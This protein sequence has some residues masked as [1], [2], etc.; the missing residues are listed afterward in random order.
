VA[1][2]SPRRRRLRRA[3]IGLAVAG[4][5]GIAAGLV[6][7]DR[8]RPQPYR[9]GEKHEDITRR[10]AR[11]IPED[12]PEP[13]FVDVT[14]AAG[15]GGF[16]TFAGPRSSQLPEDMG[17]G[18]A[19][20]DYDG[21]GD[22]DLFV[23]GA[24]AALG[25]P[26][27]DRARSALFEN[28]GDG[29]FRPVESFPETR[30]LGM[31]AAWGDYD[32][33]GWLD[34]VVTGYQSLILFHNDSGRMVRLD[35]L[36]APAGFW[37]GASWGD[38]DGDGD[39]DLYVCGYVRYAAG[40]RAGPAS[41]RQYGQSVPYTLNPASYRPERNLLFRNDGG[42]RFTEVAGELGVANAEGRSLGALWHD[43]DDDGWLDLYVAND[44][45]DNV[46]YRNRHGSFDDVSHAAWVA[47]YRGAMGLTAG[48]W[49]RDGDDDLFVTHWVAQENALYD[50]L[51]AD[52]RRPGRPPGAG[53][54]FADQASLVGLGQIA[55]RFV[56][57]GAEFADLD[58]D[59]W[60]DLIVANGS[61]F[62]TD[63][64]PRVLQAQAPFFFWNRR[65]EFFHDLAPLSPPLAV[66][67][68]GRGLALSDY[69]GDGD[70]D[71]L[72]VEHAAGVHLLRNDTQTGHWLELR[73]RAAARGAEQRGL[74]DG[75]TVV[76]RAGSAE[77]RRSVTS[78]SYLSQSTRTLHFGLGPAGRL[79]RVEVR[80]LGGPAE[81]YGP[82]EAGAL[83]E[84]TRGGSAP[85][86]IG[87][88]APG[89]DR[90]RLAAFWLKQREAVDALKTRG[91]LP[92][93]IAL[94]REALALNPSHEDAR[95][96]LANALAEQGRVP[97]ALEQLEWLIR[98]NPQSHRAL[99]QWGALRALSARSPADLEA[100]RATLARALAVNP[101]ETGT[102]LLLGEL[103]LMGG[104]DE[105][106]ATHLEWACRTN[107][108]AV[109][110]WFLRAYIAWKRGRDGEARALLRSAREARGDPAKPP[111]AA[112]EGDV[113]R[114]MHRD[115]TPL[116]RFW[117]A[118]DGS[119]ETAEALGP[120]DAFLGAEA[121]GWRRRGAETGAPSGAGPPEPPAPDGHRPSGG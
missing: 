73:L 104:E 86:R 54:S 64:E 62:E 67:R 82:L 108:R 111:G 53:L 91:D 27:E 60:L 80:W 18:A 113:G 93:A 95:Y 23:V 47:D 51:L 24:G 102:L 38:Y 28:R 77:L 106:A 57:W 30:I 115:Q 6:L 32:G 48:D 74:A 99:K 29:T 41:T 11:G 55:L 84:I 97:E 1:P 31:G 14:E 25:R 33:D 7:H 121:A 114:R 72:L 63:T 49:N 76:A 3:A 61:T 70:L 107:P 5:G 68:V 4:L 89:G 20:G 109:G 117:E 2:L 56:G 112:A 37:A 46:L 81:T 94:F 26:A 19:W 10:L 66:P 116:G 96:Y 103:A 118:W 85:R 59:G 78:T 79:D 9:P 98:V 75:A 17:P 101:E 22:D 42:G 71:V 69:D 16:R 34:L 39:L 35:A 8:N 120:L 90:R 65:G 100:A 50:S 58:G 87:P 40:T 15:L 105:R 36:P 45:S 119:I 13:R 44:I 83:W 110:G 88:P 52:L 92:R 21:D 43:F 12:A